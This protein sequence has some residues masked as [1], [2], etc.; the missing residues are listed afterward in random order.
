MSAQLGVKKALQYLKNRKTKPDAKLREE[1]A[2]AAIE[3]EERRIL[4][5]EYVGKSLDGLRRDLDEHRD[6]Q[7]EIAA[8]LVRVVEIMEQVVSRLHPIFC[9]A[10][11][12]LRRMRRPCLLV[13]R[14]SSKLIRMGPMQAP[15]SP[16]VPRRL[17]GDLLL[18]E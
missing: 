16:L 12:S 13:M 2:D 11:N 3:R 1:D 10:A 8:T 14:L 7:K 9:F 18:S 5:L 17:A 6:V 4:A 15:L